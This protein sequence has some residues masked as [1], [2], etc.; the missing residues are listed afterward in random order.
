MVLENWLALLNTGHWPQEPKHCMPGR[1][2]SP[3]VPA[4]PRQ[5]EPF[6]RLASVFCRRLSRLELVHLSTCISRVGEGAGEVLL[7]PP[8]SVTSPLALPFSARSIQ[9]PGSAR[10]RLFSKQTA[11]IFSFIVVFEKKLFL[12]SCYR[13]MHGGFVYIRE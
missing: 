5:Q 11:V 10:L 12:L 9:P 13:L 3:A 1:P 6:Q 4:A 8:A 2:T 7:L